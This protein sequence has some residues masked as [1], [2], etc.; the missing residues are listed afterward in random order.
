LEEEYGIDPAAVQA[1]TFPPPPL[2]FL[3]WEC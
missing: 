2:S 1:L 3:I